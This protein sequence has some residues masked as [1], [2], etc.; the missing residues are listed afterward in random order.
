[1]ST[2]GVSTGHSYAQICCRA[3]LTSPD[4]NHSSCWGQ[5]H[6]Q[7]LTFLP[8]PGIGTWRF[9]LWR[10]LQEQNIRELLYPL[11]PGTGDQAA[12]KSLYNCL[13]GFEVRWVWSLLPAN[14]QWDK[15]RC[16]LHQVWLWYKQRFVHW[17]GGWALKQAAQGSITII[18]QE[19]L[20]KLCRCGTWGHRALQVT[21]VIN[22]TF[23]G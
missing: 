21:T 20:K 16:N 15:R 13:K 7:T 2:R 22:F 23:Q 3:A 4:T 9:P 1:M 12:T 8:G 10:Q 5:N 11:C 6:P 18:I 14:E 17:K 19:V